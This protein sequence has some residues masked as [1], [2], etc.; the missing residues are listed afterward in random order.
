MTGTFQAQLKDELLRGAERLRAARKRRR[1]AMVIGAAAILLIA[2]TAIAVS[3][4]RPSPA[5]AGVDIEVKDGSLTVRLTDLESRPAVILR[6]LRDAGIDA[7]VT[8]VPSGP[9]EVG[10][11]Q[12]AI[13]TGALPAKL[14]DPRDGTFIGFVVPVGARDRLDLLVGRP[15]ARGEQYLKP[16]NAFAKGE[17]LACAGGLLGQTLRDDSAKLAGAA[18]SIRVLIYA[19]ATPPTQTSLADALVTAGDWRV[20]QA[21]AFSATDL[22]VTVDVDGAPLPNPQVAPPC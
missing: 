13:G 19:P 1:R 6:A 17:P 10:R 21:A 4:V 18:P 2:A 8:A 22:I 7:T 12:L 15:A 9:S 14:L 16:S 20:V 5:S 11:F 3:V